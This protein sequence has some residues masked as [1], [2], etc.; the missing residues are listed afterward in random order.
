M[1]HH[2]KITRDLYLLVCCV[3]IGLSFGILDFCLEFHMSTKRY[4]LPLPL[5]LYSSVSLFLCVHLPYYTLCKANHTPTQSHM[6]LLNINLFQ[7]PINEMEV[8]PC[9]NYTEFF[10]DLEEYYREQKILPNKQ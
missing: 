5:S 6:F 4:E 10:L 2:H 7:L 8:S 1:T 9:I 3:V